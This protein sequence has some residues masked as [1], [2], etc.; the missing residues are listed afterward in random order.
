MDAEINDSP[1]TLITNSFF[2]FFFCYNIFFL[3]QYLG[4]NT[5]RKRFEPGH[6]LFTFPVVHSAPLK[7]NCSCHRNHNSLNFFF[8]HSHL[9]SRSRA[10]KTHLIQNLIWWEK[11]ILHRTLVVT[12]QT[13]CF[14]LII[15]LL[16]I[17]K[18]AHKILKLT[19]RKCWG[20]PNKW[21]LP[22]LL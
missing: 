7:Y 15:Q 1:G 13:L 11:F 4:F 21:I 12:S 3:L 22:P 9:K 5:T 6:N 16:V 2:F 20:K 19:H 18:S 17:I 10:A 8:F 14:R